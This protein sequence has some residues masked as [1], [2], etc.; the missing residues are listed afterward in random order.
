MIAQSGEIV[1]WGERDRVASH[2]PP[3]AGRT[4]RQS[5]SLVYS[6]IPLTVYAQAI[7]LNTQARQAATLLPAVLTA[8]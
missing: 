6:A 8:A 3:S 4:R 1:K 5:K 7:F 2:V